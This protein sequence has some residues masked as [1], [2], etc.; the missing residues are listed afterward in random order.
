MLK[1]QK[2]ISKNSEN[3]EGFLLEDDRVCA[4]DKILCLPLNNSIWN[5]YNSP[6]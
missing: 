6:Q 2:E 3:S 4:N 5:F 1:S